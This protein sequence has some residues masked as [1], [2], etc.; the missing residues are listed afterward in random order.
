MEMSVN[1]LNL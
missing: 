1:L